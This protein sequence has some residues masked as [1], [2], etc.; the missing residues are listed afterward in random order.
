[1]THHYNFPDKKTKK[2]QQ[3]FYFENKNDGVCL[4]N[5]FLKKYKSQ[6]KMTSI[7][8]ANNSAS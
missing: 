1:M 4:K 2:Q 6:V 5:E 3:K 7:F 8:F